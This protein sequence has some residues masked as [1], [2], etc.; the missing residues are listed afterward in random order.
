MIPLTVYTALIGKE[1]GD[2]LRQ[3]RCG[4]DRRVR[5]VC[6][7]DRPIRDNGRWKIYS[8]NPG[9]LPDGTTVDCPRRQARYYKLM[10]HLVLPDSERWIWHDACMVLRRDPWELV[11]F[12]AEKPLATFHHPARRCIYDEHRACVKYN[13]DSH[14]VMQKQI[15]QMRFLGYP[16]ENGLAETACL[17]RVNQQTISRF[18]ERWW[19]ILAAYSLRDQLSF[20]FVCWEQGMKY[21]KVPGSRCHS[22]HFRIFRQ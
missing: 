9:R 15:D 21:G 8:V 18:N 12:A 13:K 7:T 19:E 16:P 1:S 11:S 3:P 14:D 20:D 6:F 4:P 17:V 10:P 5:F 2:V 22:P